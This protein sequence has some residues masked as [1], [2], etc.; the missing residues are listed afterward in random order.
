M[1][2]M[3]RKLACI[4]AGLVGQGWA[5]LFS[6]KGFEVLLQDVNGVI[7]EKAVKGISS[8]LTFLETKELIGPGEASAA[9]KRIRTATSLSEAVSDADFVQESVPDDYE[10]KRE[11]FKAMDDAAPGHAILASSASGLMMSDIQT[12]TKRPERCIMVHPALPVHLIPLVEIAGGR[13][14]SA[15]TAEATQALMVKLG[16]TPVLLKKE[17]PGYIINRLQAALMREAIDLVDKG[18]ASAEDIDKAFLKG[19]G[20]RD[21]FIGPFLRMHLAADGV[22]KFIENYAQSYHHRWAS[23]ETWTS[24]PPSAA[25]AVVKGIY[26]MEIIRTKKLEE[27]KS[28]RDE[29]LVKSLKMVR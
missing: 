25:E 2:N 12:A 8:N 27:I 1:E 14:T 13:Q 21:P 23:M 3:T 9:V 19:I 16:K 15:E 7:L 20:L 6:S 17:V 22:E 26:D 5:T 28:W 10:L 24:I 4:G 29:M 11:V 18:V